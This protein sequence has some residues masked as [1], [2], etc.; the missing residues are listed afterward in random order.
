MKNARS[1]AV[2][3]A[4]L[5]LKDFEKNNFKNIKNLTPSIILFKKAKSQT[6]LESIEININ[7]IQGDYDSSLLEIKELKTN[8]TDEN[9]LEINTIINNFV[10]E[11]TES[12][13]DF[14]MFKDDELITL[15]T[16][17][18]AKGL[19]WKKVYI[20]DPKNSFINNQG[21]ETKR[22]VYV[23]VSRAKDILTFVTDYYTD[24]SRFD[25]NKTLEDYFKD[26]IRSGNIK[27][28]L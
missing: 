5:E 11:D 7:T 22:L 9:L 10:I 4:L 25:H 20:Y 12:Q 23:A 17:H 27:V 6:K 18:K 19:E 15:S 28:I 24:Q 2:K 13:K 8:H 3:K 1:T 14:T 16:I 21:E 26:G